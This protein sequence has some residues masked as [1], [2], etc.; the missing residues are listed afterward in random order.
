MQL[1]FHLSALF[2]ELYTL[3]SSCALFLILAGL[4][5]RSYHQ[6]PFFDIKHIQERVGQ[7]SVVVRSSK[8]PI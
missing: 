8:L 6:P 2:P 3:F 5:D 4:S 7:I 1:H